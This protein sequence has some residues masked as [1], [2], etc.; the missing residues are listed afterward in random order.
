MADDDSHENIDSGLDSNA[1]TIK[2]IEQ[3]NDGTGSK[4]AFNIKQTVMTTRS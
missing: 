3:K 1:L 2:V 4:R